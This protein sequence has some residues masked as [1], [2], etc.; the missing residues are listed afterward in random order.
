MSVGFLFFETSA[1][2]LFNSKIKR[3]RTGINSI[4]IF[5]WGNKKIMLVA[6]QLGQWAEQTALKLLK[7]QNY[8]WVASNYHS[9]R[10][11]VDLIVKRGNELIFVEVKARGQGN[12]GQACEMVT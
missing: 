3:H 12:Y 8:E 4:Y 2:D 6:Q 11:E 9:R 7:E 10:G 1:F 5:N